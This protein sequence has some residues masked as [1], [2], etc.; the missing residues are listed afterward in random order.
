MVSFILFMQVISSASFDVQIQNYINLKKELQ[1]NTLDYLSNTTENDGDSYQIIVHT[2]N[3]LQFA[4]QKN[5]MIEFL[6]FLVKISNNYHRHPLLYKKIEKILELIKKDM[7]ELLSETKIFDIFKSN[8]KL[9]LLLF[10]E[11]IISPNQTI[12][13]SLT[14]KKYNKLNYLS[15]FYPEMKP[16]IKEK[17]NKK[18]YSYDSKQPEDF[19]HYYN[20]DKEIFETNRKVG[21]NNYYICS[22]IRNDSVIDFISYATKNS[23]SLKQN[24]K[25]SIFETNKFLINKSPTLIE[26]ATF[27]GSIQIFKYLYQNGVELQS[28]LWMYA[29]HGNNPEIIHF[30]EENHI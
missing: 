20:E 13:K 24:V 21:E 8:K 16:F 26:Y 14:S 29:I 27:F 5:D 12:A 28:S 1:Q 11:K 4:Q 6:H 7:K 17:R 22:L 23:L 9:L 2:I 25:S 19:G 10:E 15:Y 3:K 18:K 30:L